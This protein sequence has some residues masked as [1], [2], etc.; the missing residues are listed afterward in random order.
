MRGHQDRYGRNHDAAQE[1]RG[2][3]HLLRTHG[4]CHPDQGCHH[5]GVDHYIADTDAR[6]HEE[7]TQHVDALRRSESRRASPYAAVQNHSTRCTDGTAALQDFTPVCV[8][9]GSGADITVHLAM[10][11]LPLKADKAPTC[12]HV[13]FVPKAD[14]CSAAN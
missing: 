4:A 7:L 11:A 8:R 10:S 3:G 1:Y 12:W 13:R 6:T 5:Q 9:F 14:I 2:V